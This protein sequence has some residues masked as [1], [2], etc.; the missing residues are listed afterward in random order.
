MLC[1][2]FNKLLEMLMVTVSFAWLAELLGSTV[3]ME[4]N[5]MVEDWLDSG[6]LENGH[7]WDEMEFWRV[8]PCLFFRR[9]AARLLLLSSALIT[10]HHGPAVTQHSLVTQILPLSHPLLSDP[11]QLLTWVAGVIQI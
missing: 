1:L 6:E 10:G 3:G 2:F 5:P 8:N 11:A 9:F 7:V 4:L